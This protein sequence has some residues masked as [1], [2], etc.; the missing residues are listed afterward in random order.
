MGGIALGAQRGASSPTAATCRP[1]SLWGALAVGLTPL[2]AFR[3]RLRSIEDLDLSPTP[4]FAPEMR[5]A[6][7]PS[8]GPVLVTLTYRVQPDAEHD[9][10]AAMRRLRGARRGTGATSWA[11]YRDTAQE[12]EFIETFVVPT[13]GEH[14]RQH[15]RRTADDAELQEALRPFLVDGE[16][17]HAQ[18]YVA[19]D[20]SA[21]PD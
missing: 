4:M 9:F 16:L 7:E 19:A 6:P 8:D 13:W 10:L 3:W 20:S 5:L 17:P 12:H 14:V 1:R 2:L 21:D 18:H 11:V 15:A